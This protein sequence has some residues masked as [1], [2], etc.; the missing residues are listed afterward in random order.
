MI[1]K[2]YNPDIRLQPLIECF[3]CSSG[4]AVSERVHKVMPDGCVDILFSFTGN[5]RTGLLEGEP[6]LNGTMT[7]SF[8]VFRPYGI[9]DMV[10]VRFRPAGITAFSRLP[11]NEITDRHLGLTQVESIFSPELFEDLPD[12]KTNEQRISYIQEYLL[13]RLSKF[14]EPDKRIVYVTEEIIRND[15]QLNVSDLINK[16]CLSERQF[17]RRFKSSVGLSA[18]TFSKI[19]RFRHTCGYILSHPEESLYSVALSC[20]YYDHSH[21]TKDFKRFSGQLPKEVRGE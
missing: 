16:V 3:W 6:F 14:Y 9:T 18:K 20:G 4:M 11:V 19:I 8:E 15:G 1:Y 13:G 7:Y 17:E 2:E 21:L 5:D 12:F 10:G